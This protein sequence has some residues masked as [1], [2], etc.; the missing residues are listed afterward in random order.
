MNRFVEL[1]GHRGA[2]GLAPENTLVSFRQALHHQVDCIEIDVGMTRD[3]RIVI[4]H[5]RS[6]NPDITR[7]DGDWITGRRYLKDLTA[8][9][10]QAFD[11]GRNKP[12]THYAREFPRQ[13]PNDGARNAMLG[14]L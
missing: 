5:D 14:D 1:Q 8:S 4:H 2:R 6:L 9:Q 11:V 3:G 12:G 13:H 10:L 7:L